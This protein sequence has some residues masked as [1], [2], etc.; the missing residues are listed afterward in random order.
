MPTAVRYPDCLA[1]ARATAARRPHRAMSTVTAP[2]TAD[3]HRDD[4]QRRAATGWRRWLFATDHKD[5]GTMVLLF[6]GTMFMVGG[7]FA[8]LIRLELLQPGLQYFN[9]ELYNQC[10]SMHGLLMVFGAIMPAF[11]GFANWMIPLQVGAPDMAFAHMNNL[12]LWLLIPAGAR[13]TSS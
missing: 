7:A 10:V 1:A 4:A 8:M 11:V 3:A 6:S 12:S 5:I 13:S 2:H 9:S